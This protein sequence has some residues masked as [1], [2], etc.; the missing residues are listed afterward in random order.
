VKG[1]RRLAETVE[2]MNA[3]STVICSRNAGP[4]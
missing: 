2:W 3:A 1:L 4:P